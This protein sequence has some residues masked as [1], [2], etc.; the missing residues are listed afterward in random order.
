MKKCFLA[1][2][3]SLL[4]LSIHSCK[5][6][7]ENEPPKEYIISG[8]DLFD[9]NGQPM[10]RIGMQDNNIISDSFFMA[11]FPVPCSD[12]FSV[13]LGSNYL[14]SISLNYKLVHVIY[15]DAPDS[16][17]SSYPIVINNAHL[18]GQTAST[19]SITIEKKYNLHFQTEKLPS[20]FYRLF[21]ENSKGKNYWQNVL[22]Q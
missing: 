6:E 2:L 13:A 14:D 1:L 3:T 5:K 12:N 16:V 11:A 15:P 9:I 10:G 8:L 19:G 7:N 22:V 4:F 21:V 17:F 18:V 20:G